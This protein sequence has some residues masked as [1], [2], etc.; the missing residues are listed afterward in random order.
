VKAS[1]DMPLIEQGFPSAE[2][3]VALKSADLSK[4]KKLDV[5]IMQGLPICVRAH[6]DK[7]CR[8]D[9]QLTGSQRKQQQPAQC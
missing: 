5:F 1:P 7:R 2:G 8:R 9:W 6:S 3:R 4:I